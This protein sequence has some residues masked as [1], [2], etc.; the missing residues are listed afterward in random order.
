MW[1]FKPND[2]KSIFSAQ[3]IYKVYHESHF[4]L[5]Y[6]TCILY[7]SEIRKKYKIVSVGYRDEDPE[8]SSAYQKCL[9]QKLQY[10]NK[11]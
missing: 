8:E 11:L 2:W 7:Y 10:E 6:L 3:S 1:P 5:K 4:G 9:E